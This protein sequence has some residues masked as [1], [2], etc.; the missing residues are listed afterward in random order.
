MNAN[1]VYLSAT[2]TASLDGLAAHPQAVSYILPMERTSSIFLSF[3][4]SQARSV[5]W[6]Q[7]YVVAEQPPPAAGTV[8]TGRSSTSATALHWQ[9]YFVVAR[10]VQLP[11]AGLLRCAR[12]PA[13]TGTH[14][15]CRASRRVSQS[16]RGT[17]AA[18]SASGNRHIFSCQQAPTPGA[19]SRADPSI[20]RRTITIASS[21][22]AFDTE[23]CQCRH[24]R[25]RSM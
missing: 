9:N 11:A 2:G 12:P 18:G 10:A 7:F 16:R 22:T 20:C 13:L 14:C 3:T 24:G 15:C 5:A 1:C 19:G 21:N 6:L 17:L 8:G 23:H 4:I 25:K